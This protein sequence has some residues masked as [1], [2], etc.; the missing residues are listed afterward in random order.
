MT[1]TSQ[2]PAVTDYLVAKAQASQSLGASAAA[3]VRVI[4]GPP[5]TGDA[6]A[7]QRILYVGWDQVNGT[8]DGDDAAQSW[9]LM[10]RARTREEDG[11]VT[12]TADAWSG[13]SVLKTA[14]D[15][16][17]AIVGGVELLLR[18]DGSTGPGDATMGRLVFWSAVEDLHWYP[19]QDQQGAG[20]A[21]VFTVTFRARLTTT[22]A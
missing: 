3:P 14:R 1:I 17:A 16:C 21:C 15:M 8:A 9:S 6:L 4:D 13:S 20:M 2:V 22:G 10:D 5:P 7:E 11:T 18:G 19:R 12:C